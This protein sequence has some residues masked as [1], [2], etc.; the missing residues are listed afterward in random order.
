MKQITIK[1]GVAFLDGGAS[2]PDILPVGF[3][4]H[5]YM[6]IENSQLFKVKKPFEWKCFCDERRQAERNDSQL[7]KSGAKSTTRYIMDLERVIEHGYI[8]KPDL[9][10]ELHLED[11]AVTF[12]E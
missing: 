5:A 12:Y 11:G 9:V 8:G 2:I 6:D 3:V 7:Y 1:D 10:F 4:I